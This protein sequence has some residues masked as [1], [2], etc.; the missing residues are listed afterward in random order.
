MLKNSAQRY[1]AVT[2]SLHWTIALLIM[3]LIGL[4]WYMVGLTY[5][6][7]WYN[8]SLTT[9]RALGMLVLALAVLMLVWRI[10]SRPPALVA[11]I[12]PWER[13]A[14]KAVHATLYLMM[15]AIPIT[16]YT[17][18]TSAGGTIPVFGWFEIPALYPVDEPLRDFAIT[19]HYYL[20]YGTA[21]LIALHAL[22]ALK[23][24]FIDRD[25]TLGKML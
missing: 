20:A 7:P 14:A 18:S 9:H 5:Y 21:F 10:Y 8:D 16:G 12:K 17:I 23:H 11:T 25:G 1:G 6:D 13:V 3:G 24:Q 4:G 19:V 2:K 15:L 22:A